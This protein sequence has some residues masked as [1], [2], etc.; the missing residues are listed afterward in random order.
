MC[1]DDELCSEPEAVDELWSVFGAPLVPDDS[2]LDLLEILC[3]LGDVV[4][5]VSDAH[6]RHNM[7][8]NLRS[9]IAKVHTALFV[10]SFGAGGSGGSGSVGL[11]RRRPGTGVWGVRSVEAASVADVV[12]VAEG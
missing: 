11:L 8:D 7:E 12:L 10:G 1:S 2:D 5:V 6:V 3:H 9:R 4:H